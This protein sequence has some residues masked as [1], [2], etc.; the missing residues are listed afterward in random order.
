MNDNYL[1]VSEIHLKLS[2]AIK[3]AFEDSF[4]FI[5]EISELR[6]NYSGHCYLE[7]I[8]K[9][10]GSDTIKS[11]I[12]ATIWSYQYQ[13]IKPFFE[14][15]TGQSLGV[16]MKVLM[17]GSLEN[18]QLYGLSL[19]IRDIDPS[20]TLGE[21]QKRRNEILLRLLDEGVAEMNQELE[22]PLLPKNIAVVSSET[23]AGYGDFYDQIIN[24]PEGFSFSIT[25]FQSAMQGEKT[26][27]SIINALDEIYARV[28]E[29]DLVVI[30][31]GG[32]ATSDLIWFDDYDIAVNIA[33]FPLPVVS[34]IGH[35]R[36]ET[37]VD[38][39]ANTRV[40][41]PTAAAEFLIHIARNAEALLH[42]AS[43]YFKETVYEFLNIR[44]I[45][46]N[47]LIQ[48]LPTLIYRS[49]QNEFNKINSMKDRVLQQSIRYLNGKEKKLASLSHSVLSGAS[50]LFI[51][52]EGALHDKINLLS[53]AVKKHLDKKEQHLNEQLH[54]LRRIPLRI[55]N[56][57]LR[58][59]KILIEVESKDPNYVLNQGYTLLTKG[60]KIIASSE[61]LKVGDEVE[62]RIKQS[63][64]KSTVTQIE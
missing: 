32:G 4:W 16:G 24:N 60:G 44:G 18:H 40:K 63:V 45:K 38:M 64:I 12:R 19:N 47:K 6:V 49:Q 11:K 21:Q 59:D 36:D 53:K 25:L 42:D 31:R 50:R 29:F 58:L 9:Q 46:L 27:Q 1:S 10:E 15:R 3:V 54:L 48:Q 20:Y 5:G 22:L 34:A 30:L 2:N 14:T 17:K 37:I 8:E 51:A 13:M 35:E 57:E 62:N 39:I 33:Q 61:Q 26:K 23:A 41:T 7:L 43:S 52:R 28:N 56:E 55:I